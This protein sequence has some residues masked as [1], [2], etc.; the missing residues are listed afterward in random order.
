MI[1]LDDAIDAINDLPNC[2]NGYSGSYDKASIISAL[3]EVPPAQTEIIRCKDCKHRPTL[4]GADGHIEQG[5]SLEFPDNVCPC[6]CEDCWY[7]WY[8]SDDFYCG[9]AERREDENRRDDTDT[10]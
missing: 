7:N 2:P 4:T 9:R 8:P 1:Y 10:R 5:F 6:Q 3:E